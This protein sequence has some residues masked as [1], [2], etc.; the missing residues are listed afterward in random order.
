MKRV[1]DIAPLCVLP[2]EAR[3]NPGREGRPGPRDPARR[4]PPPTASSPGP[5]RRTHRTVRS[6]TAF[7]GHLQRCA[8]E[9]RPIAQQRRIHL[10]LLVG[11]RVDDDVMSAVR[12]G[13]PQTHRH[14]KL[15]LARLRVLF[16]DV[17]VQRERVSKSR[18]ELAHVQLSLRPVV[19]R[20]ERLRHGDASVW[21]GSRGRCRRSRVSCSLKWR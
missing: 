12:V 11:I 15:L 1:A 19:S 16:A 9:G 5:R 21:R 2:G 4:W 8:G 7:H 3:S 10:L 18:H 17:P 6:C 20:I 14:R 13:V